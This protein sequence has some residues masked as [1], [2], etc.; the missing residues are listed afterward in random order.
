MGLGCKTAA[1][2]CIEKRLVSMQ[3]KYV[4]ALSSLWMLTAV[5]PSLAQGAFV[6]VVTNFVVSPQ[7]HEDR[8]IRVMKTERGNNNDFSITTDTQRDSSTTTNQ[9]GGVT[10]TEVSNNGTINTSII[11]EQG[12]VS[13]TEVF[14]FTESF[15]YADFVNTNTVTTGFNGESGP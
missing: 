5:F 3:I 12:R 11:K 7:G 10:T 13:I 15:D 1:V 6:T 2:Y 14:E 8:T 4:F 9:T